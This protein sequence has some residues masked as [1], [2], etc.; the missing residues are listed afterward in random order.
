M[1]NM[2]A[3]RPY[4]AFLAMIERNLNQVGPGPR[5]DHMFNVESGV[6]QALGYCEP[7]RTLRA[8]ADH[9]CAEAR[10]AAGGCEHDSHRALEA[11][12]QALAQSRP[13]GRSGDIGSTW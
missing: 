2:T 7:N 13:S 10:K 12:K 3:D 11:F 5:F 1:Q 4:E 9:L 8:A 6:R